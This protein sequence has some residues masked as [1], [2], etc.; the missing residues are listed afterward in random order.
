MD[1]KVEKILA[2]ASEKEKSELTVLNNAVVSNIRAYRADP[3]AANKKNWDA[4]Q[5]GFDDLVRVLSEKYF[6]ENGGNSASLKN[7]PAVVEYLTKAGWKIAKSAAYKH[8]KEGKLVPGPDGSFKISK[9]DRYADRW[10]DRLSGSGGA[11]AMAEEKAKA[12]LEKLKAQARHWD[13]KTK[14]QLG[15]YVPRDLF[16]Y[17]IAARA[18][19]FKS[20]IEGFFRGRASEIVRTCD[21]NP[22]TIPVL[23]DYLIAQSEAWLARYSRPKKWKVNLRSDLEKDV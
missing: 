8:K 7:I 6:Q 23:I 22:E 18:K 9:V 11:D 17:E 5:A 19:V 4:A 2:V 13:I 21:G 14:I 1:Q 12:E 20:D 16:E 3:T 15:E 10:L